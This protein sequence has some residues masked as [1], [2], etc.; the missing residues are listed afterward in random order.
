MYFGHDNPRSYSCKAGKHTAAK[1][2]KPLVP[3]N[4]F[5]DLDNADRDVRQA[6]GV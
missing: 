6:H 3:A 2:P 4:V 1:W 5:D